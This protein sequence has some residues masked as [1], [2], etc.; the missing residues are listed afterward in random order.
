M[1]LRELWQSLTIAIKRENP[2]TSKFVFWYALAI[3]VAVMLIVAILVLPMIQDTIRLNKEIQEGKIYF[4]GQDPVLEPNIDDFILRYDGAF[5]LQKLYPLRLPQ[6]SW[7]PNELERYWDDIDQK[8]LK[9]L[10]R[11]NRKMLEQQL[12]NLP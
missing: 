12:Q 2:L 6:D 10:R 7:S 1:K 4:R 9:E 11:E 8:K 5:Q 3:I